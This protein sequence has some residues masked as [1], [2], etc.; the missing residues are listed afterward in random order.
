MNVAIAMEKLH[1][2]TFIVRWKMGYAPVY[3]DPHMCT[4]LKKVVKDSYTDADRQMTS[5]DFSFFL[6]QLQGL[7]FYTGCKM[8]KDTSLH[9]ATFDFDEYALLNT[10]ETY[11]RILEELGVL[12]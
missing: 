5:E 1:D 3:N 11:V 4:L 9:N 6:K 7:M 2:V 10:V 8:E 12:A